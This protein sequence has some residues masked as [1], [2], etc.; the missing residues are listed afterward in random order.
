MVHAQVLEAYIHFTLMYTAD[1]I[2]PLLPNKDLINEDGQL[3]MK[4]KFVTGRKPS[5]SLFFFWFVCCTKIYCT[6]WY[7]GVK[8]ASPIA[9]VICGIFFGIIQHQKGYL[10]YV[11]HI[12]KIISL[13]N[14]VFDESFSRALEYTSLPYTES[15][16]VRTDVSYI[17]YAAYS[18]GGTVDI[19]KFAQF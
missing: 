17:M 3:T 9:K 4:F 2:F 6:C 5:I 12:W 14:V 7:K 10:V 1:H 19:I 13:Y 16:A 18:R 8:Y 15:M 11:P